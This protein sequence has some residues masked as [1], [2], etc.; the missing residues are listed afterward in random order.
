MFI[1]YR[2]TGGVFAFL[3]LAAV[4]LAATVLTAAVAAILL[5]VAVGVAATALLARLA[6]PALSRHHTASPAPRWPQ[7]TIETTAVNT[8]GSAPT[9]AIPFA[10]RA[11]KD[12]ERSSTTRRRIAFFR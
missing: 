4:A 3:T 2:R 7:D 9:N 8:M 5:I 1:T 11:T 6:L 10:W 12:D